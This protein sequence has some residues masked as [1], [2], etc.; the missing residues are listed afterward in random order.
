V[1]LAYVVHRGNMAVVGNVGVAVHEVAAVVWVRPEV[2][3]FEVRVVASAAAVRERLVVAWEA[4]L[5]AANGPMSRPQ[6][7]AR[8]TTSM[9]MVF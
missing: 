4:V 2:S 9:R 5:P 8:R 7:T 3:E 6:T 1:T